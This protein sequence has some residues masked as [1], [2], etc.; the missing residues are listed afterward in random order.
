MGTKKG[1]SIHSER[2][3]E[4]VDLR[5]TRVHVDHANRGLAI[6][7]KRERDKAVRELS[8]DKEAVVGEGLVELVASA[9][10]DEV[11]HAEKKKIF[12]LSDNNLGLLLVTVRRQQGAAGRGHGH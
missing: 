3:V 8:L 2:Q 1:Y 11:M 10:R 5:L 4:G 12:F 7:A 9:A 6:V